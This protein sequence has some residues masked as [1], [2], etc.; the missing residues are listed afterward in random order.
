MKVVITGGTGF[1]GARLARRILDKGSL[2]GPD[3]AQIQVDEVVLFDVVAPDI[4]PMR[5]DGQVTLV[6]GD[7][8]DRAT[9]DRLIDRDD[10]SVFHLASVVSGGGEKDF[11]DV[12][13]EILKPKKLEYLQWESDDESEDSRSQVENSQTREAGNEWLVEFAAAVKHAGN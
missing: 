10:I 2:A 8:S 5:L 4:L 9:V 13:N 1:I 6:T 3:G 7:I 12:E 11:D